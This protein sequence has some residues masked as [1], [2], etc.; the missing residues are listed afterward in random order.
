M[1][2]NVGELEGL[3]Q[4]L[5][6]FRQWFDPAPQSVQALEAVAAAFPEQGDVWAKSIQLGEGSKV[7]CSGFARNQAGFDALRDRL[8][9]RSDVTGLQVQQVRGENPVQFSVTYKW[10]PHDAK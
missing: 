4:K 10:E 2:K 8:R 9:S 5:R 7:T 3:Q 6:Q 1:R